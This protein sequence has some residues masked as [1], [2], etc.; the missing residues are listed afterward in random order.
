MS[1]QVKICGLTDP[2]DAIGCSTSGADAIGVVFYPKSP[3]FVEISRAA[4]IARCVAG[5]STLVGVFVDSP[6]DEI[7]NCIEK[8]GLGVVQLHGNERPELVA[9]LKSADVKVV[10]VLKSTGRD[11]L[12]EASLFAGLADAFL[13]EAGRGVLPGGNAAAWD[14]GGA[15]VLKDITPFALA[16]GLSVENVKDAIIASG[17]DAV[18][19]S[20]GVEISPGVKNIKMVEKFISMAKSLD[21]NCRS[22]F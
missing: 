6:V 1:V 14:W 3:R 17:C 22:V 19:V 2:W 5:Y 10:K 20:S 8:C 11:L 7:I 18:D 21:V 13:V 16:G 4:E 12:E 15:N 9:E